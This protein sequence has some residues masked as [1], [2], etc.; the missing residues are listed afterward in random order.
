MFFGNIVKE[1]TGLINKGIHSV[2]RKL[3]EINFINSLLVLFSFQDQFICSVFY[4]R[5]Y[6]VYNQDHVD[7]RTNFEIQETII[8]F[9]ENKI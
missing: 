8:Q 2:H 4:S 3:F 7:P 5:T 6:K 9:M 1:K